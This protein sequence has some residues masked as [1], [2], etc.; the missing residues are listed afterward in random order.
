MNCDDVVNCDDIDP[1]VLALM[2]PAAWKAQYPGC[3]L[4]NGDLNYDGWVNAFDLTPFQKAIANRSIKADAN[5]DGC[6]NDDDVDAFVMALTNPCLY[7]HKFV[8]CPILNC[9]VNEDGSVDSFDIGP[10]ADKL[11]APVKGDMNC[12]RCINDDDVDPF[13]VAL[14]DPDEYA[15][16]YPGCD[17]LNGDLDEDGLVTAFD[18]DPFGALLAAPCE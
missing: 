15:I 17:I 4:L 11:V 5:C 8:G 6:I 1:F 13:M 12:D 10:F 3:N 9:D 2:D 18:V 16:Q 7:K 14:V